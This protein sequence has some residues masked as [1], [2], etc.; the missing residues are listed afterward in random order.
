MNNYGDATVSLIESVF[1]NGVHHAVALMR[2]SAREFDPAVHDLTNPLTEE[3][4]ECCLR[5]GKAL[6]KDLTLRGYASPAVRCLETAELILAS[7]REAGGEVTRHR[8]VEALGVFYVL[9]QMIRCGRVCM[10]LAGWSTICGSG[11]PVA[12]LRMR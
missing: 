9:D 8:P 7:H 1:A 4:R 2:H 5:F 12:C 10:K 3:G 6:P 11:L